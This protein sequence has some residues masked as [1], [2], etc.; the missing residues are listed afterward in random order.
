MIRIHARSCARQSSREPS[1]ERFDAGLPRTEQRRD[2]DR[3]VAQ[4]L[5]A[6]NDELVREDA[7]LTQSAGNETRISAPHGKTEQVVGL[8]LRAGIAQAA[9]ATS[10]C[11]DR[12]CADRW[13][14]WSVHAQR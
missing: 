14:A 12:T 6:G 7:D 13:S 11:T 9:V 4:L 2:Y 10:A 8:A 1:S 5:S 3:L